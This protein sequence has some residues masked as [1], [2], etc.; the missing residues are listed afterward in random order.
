MQTL[1]TKITSINLI[2]PNGFE[3]VVLGNRSKH[4][5][6]KILMEMKFFEIDF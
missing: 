3:V 4:I 1:M 2:C 5:V 6:V